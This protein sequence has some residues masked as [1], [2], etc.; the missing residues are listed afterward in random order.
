MR[1]KALEFTFT[2]LL[3]R[4]MRN[5]NVAFSADQPGIQ[6]YTELLLHRAP[7]THAEMYERAAAHIHGVDRDGRL[8]LSRL[9]MS[10]NPASRTEFRR[11]LPRTVQL[12]NAVDLCWSNH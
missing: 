6:S 7:K 10:V 12:D 9:R 5:L 3:E 11:P 2:T 8:S 4:M 1:I